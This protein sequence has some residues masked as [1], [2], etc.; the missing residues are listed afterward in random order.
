[1]SE[2]SS[3]PAPGAAKAIEASKINISFNGVQV[4]N[5][6]DFT[7]MEGEIH[8]LVGM[9][10]AGKSTLVKILNG[11]YHRDSGEIKV[12]GTPQNYDS[13][14]GAND[15][16]IAMVY[17]DLSLVPSMTVAQNIF[18][19]RPFRSGPLIDDV[20]ARREARELFERMEI[21]PIDPDARVEEIS[22]GQCQLVEIAKALSLEAKILILDEP[23]AS[24]SNVEI[25]TLFETVNRLKNSGIS[26]I[27]ITHY[28][29]DIFRICDR[30]TILRDGRRVLTKAVTDLS[31]A[32]MID[33][34]LGGATREGAAWQRHRPQPGE[35]PLL[36]ARNISTDKV[37]EASFCI[38]PGEI[39]G[40]A[41]LLGS[42]RTE[43]TRALFGLD[44]LKS[45]QI[46]LSGKPVNLRDSRDALDN[47]ISLVPEDRRQQ[48]LVLDFSIYDNM[49]LPILRRLSGKVLIDRRRSAELVD[50][51]FKHLDVKAVG[52]HQEARMLSGGNQ[53]KV[54]VG[55]FLACEPRVL[56][57]DDPT[58][59]IDI[60]AK[61]EI[62]RIVKEFA[63][64]G[65]GVLFIS[66][67]LHEISAFCDV[68]HIVRRR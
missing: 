24:L 54:V 47:G 45:G 65:N 63:A 29:K 14:Q 59:G 62:M 44:R 13:P 68:V 36:E 40:L 11:F 58:F 38:Y 16:G 15:A 66:S 25:G 51:Y 41:G 20:R 28:L 12:F 31:M 5:D 50:R 52:P 21:E 64:Q 22:P 57:L 18:L 4:L 42:G 61:R 55:K 3:T 26:I 34:M 53:Q 49:I 23:T 7:L 67:E 46:L 32:E 6:V 37:E 35:Q 19:M 60:H 9:N 33:E 48:G 43:I 8:A 10:G 1:M 27:Y 56:L 39:V 17:Q 30:A 2:Q